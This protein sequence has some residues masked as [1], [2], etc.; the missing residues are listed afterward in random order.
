MAAL[1]IGIIVLGAVVVGFLTLSS[2]ARTGRTGRGV[3]AQVYPDINRGVARCLAQLEEVHKRDDRERALRNLERDIE[4]AKYL[5]DLEDRAR[6]LR[7]RA[8][9]R[10]R[11]GVYTRGSM[12][13]LDAL[14]EEI[15]RIKAR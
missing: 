5:M 2:M 11:D 1:I 12:Q 8:I 6:I 3:V 14:C 10:S 7:E 9:S 15:D 4:H 13:A